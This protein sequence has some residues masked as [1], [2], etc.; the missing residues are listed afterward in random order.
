MVTWPGDCNGVV[1]VADPHTQIAAGLEQLIILTRVTFR[2][3]DSLSCRWQR[4][5]R[6]QRIP[7]HPVQRAS[8]RPL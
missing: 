7:W 6:V 8:F 2:Y 3:R 4:V 5:A 1:P